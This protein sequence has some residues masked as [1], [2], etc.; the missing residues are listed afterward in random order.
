MKTYFIPPKAIAA[1]AWVLL[2]GS[3]TY[4]ACRDNSQQAAE[5]P[6]SKVSP[7]ETHLYTQQVSA[8]SQTT[9]T[10]SMTGKKQVVKNAVEWS[11]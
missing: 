5:I 2:F 3:I 1:C 4:E 10:D 9:L 8:P 11:K 6:K 7:G